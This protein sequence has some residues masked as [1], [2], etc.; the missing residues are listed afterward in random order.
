[1]K[2]ISDLNFIWIDSGDITDAVANYRSAV[3]SA[4]ECKSSNMLTAKT[5]LTDERYFFTRRRK[6]VWEVYGRGLEGY[7]QYLTKSEYV[8][9][10]CPELYQQMLMTGWDVTSYNDLRDAASMSDR[11][12]CTQDTAAFVK[13]WA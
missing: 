7:Y 12:W 6:S 5:L 1:M 11:V 2:H 10:K 4:D 13:R 8:M 3:L 9:D